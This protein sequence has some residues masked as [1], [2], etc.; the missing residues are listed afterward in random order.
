ML[1]NSRGPENVYERIKSYAPY[2]MPLMHNL[3]IVSLTSGSLLPSVILS[4][5]PAPLAVSFQKVK[6]ALPL[7]F[8]IDHKVIKSSHICKFDPVVHTS[9]IF[10]IARLS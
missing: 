9:I 2:A 3:R 10:K 6:L 4:L 7:P 1:N 8:V 5:Y